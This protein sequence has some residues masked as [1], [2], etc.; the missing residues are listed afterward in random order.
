M[1][2]CA[3][4]SRGICFFSALL[5]ILRIE[6]QILR[7]AQDDSSPSKRDWRVSKC[8]DKLGFLRLRRI[9]HRDPR[10]L[11]SIAG[12][13]GASAVCFSLRT[14]TCMFRCN[15]WLRGDMRSGG[16][17]QTAVWSGEMHS[18]GWHRALMRILHA[19]YDDR[20]PRQSCS[21]RSQ[22]KPLRTEESFDPREKSCLPA[23]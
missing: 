1:R 19:A 11:M 7:V 5:H 3:K 22:G 9:R 4:R 13:G 14:G 10:W 8:R 23:R 2:F 21:C 16:S 18:T 12:N 20:N 6:K 15:H 17:T